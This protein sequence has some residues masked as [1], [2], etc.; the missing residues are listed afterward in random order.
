M[1]LLSLEEI[2]ALSD[3][4][5]KI[6]YLKKG[7]KTEL[8]DRCKLW[9]DWNPERHEIMVDKEKYPDRKVLEKDAEKVFDEKT[10]KPVLVRD[11]TGN[12]GSDIVKYYNQKEMIGSQEKLKGGFLL[13]AS[14]G[15]LIYLNNRKQQLNI[16]LSFNNI[17]NNT[18]MITGGYQ[19]GR[20]SRDNKS[21]TK[22]IQ[23][24]DKF[25]NKYY[26][27]WGFNMFINV[28]FKF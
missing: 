12:K 23:S 2:L 19:Q 7:R 22:D 26:Y 3:I 18:S 21:V 24:V 9:D 5:Q 13:D 14:V 4:G 28:G 27:A 15:K 8:P 6:N 1:P 11:Y 25:P 16:N 10:G 17:L 20:V